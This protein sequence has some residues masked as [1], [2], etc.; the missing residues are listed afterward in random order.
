MR[1]QER[2]LLRCITAIDDELVLEADTARFRPK[3]WGGLIALAACLAL[4][5]ALPRLWI[6]EKVAGGFEYQYTTAP[7]P[8]AANET[9][10]S[11]NEKYE[12]P[13]QGEGTE[14][15]AQGPRYGEP[16]ILRTESIGGLYLG[17]PE[18]EITALLGDAWNDWAEPYAGN[19]GFRRV[20]WLFDT[21]EANLKS[22]YDLVLE[23]ID[24]GSGWQLNH[25]T[26]NAGCHLPLSRRNITIGSTTEEVRNAYAD[27]GVTDYEYGSFSNGETWAYYAVGG[28]WDPYDPAWSGLLFTIYHDAV[29]LITYGPWVIDDAPP[30]RS[31]D[32]LALGGVM[33]GMTEDMVQT[34]L[35]VPAKVLEDSGDGLFR[36]CY[37][38]LTVAFHSFDRTVSWIQ[39]LDGSGVRL[40]NGIDFSTGQEEVIRRYPEAHVTGGD[41][42]VD[43]CDTR[44]AIEA[45]RVTLTIETF[46]GTVTTLRL[47]DHRN[48]LLEALTVGKLT[49]H[50]SSDAGWQTVKAVDKAAKRISTVLTISEPEPGEMP[51]GMPLKWLDLGS[52][53]VVGLLGDDYAVVYTCAGD[54]DSDSNDNL[55]PHLSGR[56]EGLDDA[57]RQATANPTE[58]WEIEP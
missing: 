11:E 16:E 36:W 25:I 53:T 50:L 32:E 40:D 30:E 9:D 39:A 15:A 55:T 12:G 48:P 1:E 34:V 35:G 18:T 20:S 23:L 52:G 7:E 56:F 5:L 47:E 13:E 2:R 58:T 26:V 10:E 42:D 57:V 22:E 45:D 31:P 3:R 54:F 51:E 6:P 8:P 38:A 44:Y 28:G 33:P 19:D 27:G 21:G 46:K 29:T 37:E 43:K 17:M 4:V 14:D 24:L 41:P 49:I